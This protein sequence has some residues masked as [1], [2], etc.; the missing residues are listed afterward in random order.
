M[1][2]RNRKNGPS[3]FFLRAGKPLTFYCSP[4]CMDDEM[5]LK[6]ADLRKRAEKKAAELAAKGVELHPVTA[7]GLTLAKSFLGK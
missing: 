1:A 7:S 2:I 5:P 4:M 6:R 3:G